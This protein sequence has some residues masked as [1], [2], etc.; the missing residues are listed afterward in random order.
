MSSAPTEGV[1]LFAKE[2]SQRNPKLRRHDVL[3][4]QLKASG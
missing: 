2:L 1:D 4:F 3:S